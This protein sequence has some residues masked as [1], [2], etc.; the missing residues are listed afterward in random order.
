MLTVECISSDTIEEIEE[1]IYVL[2]ISFFVFTF[3]LVD[4]YVVGQ[5]KLKSSITSVYKRINSC[6]DLNHFGRCRLNL[7]EVRMIIVD[8][9]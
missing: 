4:L 3:K 1:Y 6:F 2:D 5:N 9:E 8:N 7:I